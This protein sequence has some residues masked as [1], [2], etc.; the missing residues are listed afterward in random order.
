M[1]SIIVAA[2]SNNV[3]GCA[4]QLPWHLPDDLRHFKSIT[5]GKPVVMG[6]KT[7]ESIGRALPGRQNIVLSRQCDFAPGGCELVSSAAAAVD[8]AGD[9]PELMVIGGSQV[10]RLFLPR[11]QRIYLTRVMADV[12]GDTHFPEFAEQHWH[13]SERIQ[14]ENDARH[15]YDFEF[16]T[17]DRSTGFERRAP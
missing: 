12:A 4:G 13:I 14:R 3:I 7:F 9:A 6:R 1:I 2:S 11:A 16:L 5:L 10:Y 8:A 15:A 17:L